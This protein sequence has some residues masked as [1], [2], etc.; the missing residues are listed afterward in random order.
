MEQA[1][2]WQ[3]DRNAVEARFT[4]LNDAFTWSATRSD[5]LS[6]GC[7]RPILVNLVRSLNQKLKRFSKAGAVRDL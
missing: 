3:Y 2:K 7:G 6:E 5:T 4:D 1:C